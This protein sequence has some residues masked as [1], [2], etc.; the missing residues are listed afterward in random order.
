MKNHRKS[1]LKKKNEMLSNPLLENPKKT[2]FMSIPLIFVIVS[3]KYSADFYRKATHSIKV[4][5]NVREVVLGDII[6]SIKK[7]SALTKFFK[8]PRNKNTISLKLEEHVFIKEENEMSFDHHGKEIKFPFK[9]DSKMFEN[10]P[11]TILKENEHHIKKPDIT[12]EGLVNKLKVKLKKPIE[13]EVRDLQ[14]DFVINKIKEVYVPIYEA[15]VVGPKKKV[16]ILRIDAI[17]KKIL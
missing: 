13:T 16:G 3:G 7:K 8:N 6:F 17:R 11:K 5:G 10:Y 14:D 12:Y 15:R 4:H 1:W 9:L 2:T